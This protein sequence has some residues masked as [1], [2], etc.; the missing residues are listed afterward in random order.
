VKLATRSGE[1]IKVEARV[2]RQADGFDYWFGLHPDVQHR[3]ALGLPED[4]SN[5]LTHAYAVAEFRSGAKQFDVMSAAEIL[6]IKARSKSRDGDGNPTGPWVTDESEM[7]KK[8]VVRR[9]C[10]LLP[11]TIEAQRMLDAEESIE[12]EPRAVTATARVAPRPSRIAARVV[13]GET[14]DAPAAVPGAAQGAEALPPPTPAPAAEPSPEPGS[15]GSGEAQAD[16]VEGVAVEVAPV[17]CDGFSEDL[18]RCRLFADHEGP[19]KNDK[20][21]W[22]R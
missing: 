21:V 14:I 12:T 22:P 19:H 7:W 6:A 5:P 17:Q 18:G 4:A 13:G 1:V 15:D 2:V 16:V 20:G 8:T 11:L 10:K 3:P 9:L